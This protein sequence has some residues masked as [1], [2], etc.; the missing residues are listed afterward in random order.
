MLATLE[1]WDGTKWVRP[2]CSWILAES[3]FRLRI[4]SKDGEIIYA[5]DPQQL[6]S[7]IKNS[8][9]TRAKSE[10]RWSSEEG[11]NYEKRSIPER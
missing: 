6:S 4:Q 9:I 5:Y 2:T 10:A 8:V 7:M 1:Y 3:P 11:S